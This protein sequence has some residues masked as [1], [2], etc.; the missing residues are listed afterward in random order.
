[1]RWPSPPISNPCHRSRTRFQGLLGRPKSRPRLSIRFFRRTNTCPPHFHRESDVSKSASLGCCDRLMQL[2]EIDLK[3]AGI[4]PAEYV[5]ETMI[6]KNFF[7]EIA[8][9]AADWRR[10]SFVNAG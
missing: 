7:R 8:E 1:M 2:A 10:Q 4:R 3:A 6:P 9:V 5:R